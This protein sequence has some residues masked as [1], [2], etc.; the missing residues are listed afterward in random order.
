MAMPEG[1]RGRLLQKLD[2]NIRDNQVGLALQNATMLHQQLN[3][4][5]SELSQ[6][7]QQGQRYVDAPVYTAAT[8]VVPQAIYNYTIGNPKMPWNWK[9]GSD[10]NLHKS[11]EKWAAADVIAKTQAVEQCMK[12][13]RCWAGYEPVP[14]KKPYTEGSCRPAGSKK[15]APKKKKSDT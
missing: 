6:K 2:P 3:D 11:I 8:E 7:M 5:K 15:K 14:G 1:M 4:P 10:M 13:A 9:E 12:S